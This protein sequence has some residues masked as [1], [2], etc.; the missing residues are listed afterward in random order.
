[1]AVIGLTYLGLGFAT[2]G[3]A[4]DL[5][6]VNTILW[7]WALCYTARHSAF[8]LRWKM[9]LKPP[10][11][12]VFQFPFYAGIMGMMT[13]SGLVSVMSAWFVL[14]SNEHTFYL[15]GFWSAGLVNFFCA[16][17]GGQWAVQGPILLEAATTLNADY[18]KTA[19]AIAWGDAWTNMSTT[20]LGFACFGHCGLES[21][22]IMGFCVLALVYTG[23]HYQCRLIAVATVIRFKKGVF[24]VIES[25]FSLGKRPGNCATHTKTWK[26]TH[27]Y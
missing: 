7:R 26:C 3:F 15:F 11:G 10:S 24:Q 25:P 18:A 20:A 21:Q 19:M 4:L 17:G 6:V 1:M 23:I 9:R 16:L 14:V 2:K 22:D 12:I 27:E 8:W 13:A 5:N